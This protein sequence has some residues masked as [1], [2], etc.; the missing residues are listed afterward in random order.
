MAEQKPNYEKVIINKSYIPSLV[1]ELSLVQNVLSGIFIGDPSD[2]TIKENA[3]RWWQGKSQEERIKI[4]EVLVAL[5]APMGVA[6][7]MIIGR[8]DLL[9]MRYISNSLRKEDAVYLIGDGSTPDEYGITIIPGGDI[10]KNTLLM[11]LDLG[12]PVSE[13]TYRAIMRQQDLIVLFAMID[14]LRTNYFLHMADH[15]PVP[16]AV[17]SDEIL[18]KITESYTA[19][20]PRWL[21]SSVLS[22]LSLTLPD[23]NKLVITDSLT[24]LISLD[25]ITGEGSP[26][27]VSLTKSGT[28]LYDSLTQKTSQ[29]VIQSLCASEDG[30]IIRM[31]TVF[32]R[33]TPLIWWIDLGGPVGDSALLSGISLTQAEALISEQ[34]TP[35]ALP[36]VIKAKTP[37]QSVQPA[38]SQLV[39]SG[40]STMI[41]CPKCGNAIP[42]NKKFCPKCGVKIV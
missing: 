33:S 11:H 20:D 4:R 16:A 26:M 35:I 5:A 37:S 15:T 38:V 6:D 14:T 31:S 21:L 39:A 42:P 8:D 12:L 41:H 17:T 29:I 2:R 9:P 18:K 22:G 36:P 28:T 40:D 3:I 1:A 30:T 25:F 23:F 24:R 13:I 34:L 27:K 10:L 19:Y 32:V 7:I